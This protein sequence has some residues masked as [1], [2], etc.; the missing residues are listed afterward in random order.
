MKFIT[1]LHTIHHLRY[2]QIIWRMRCFFKKSPILNK[3]NELQRSTPLALGKKTVVPFISSPIIIEGNSFTFLNLS[4]Q[5]QSQLNWNFSSYGRLWT[6]NLNYFDFLLQPDMAEQKGLSL[7]KNYCENIDQIK[8]G[9]EPYPVSLR[10]INWIKFI[11]KFQVQDKQIDRYLWTQLNLLQRNL[12]YHLMGNHLLENAFALTIGSAYFIDTKL[13]KKAH[14]LLLNELEEQILEDGAH[15]ELSPMY[16]QIILGRL[17]DTINIGKASENINDI[18]PFLETKAGLMLGWL[19]TISFQNGDIPL[20]NDSAHNIA[21]T[22]KDLISYG[23]KLGIKP[24]SKELG[25]SGYRKITAPSQL[26]ECILDIGPIGPDYQ[27]GHAHADTFTFVL[28]YKGKPFILDTGT[29]T[30]ESG[31]RRSMERSTAAHNT[32]DVNGQDSSEVWASHRVGK[33]AR[34]NIMSETSNKIIASHNGFK[35]L[36]IIHQR[37]FEFQSKEL[38]ILDELL[39]KS[40]SLNENIAHLHFAPGFI[41]VIQQNAIKFNKGPTIKFEGAQ[42]ILHKEYLFAPEFNKTIPAQ[43]IEITF[44]KYLKTHIHFENS[45]SH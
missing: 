36:N 9:L 14:K 39:T 16:H 41:P 26:Y 31:K 11:L 42:K 23:N 33:R 4:H 5:F 3:K 40:D 44:S 29:S 10:C 13:Y 19:K 25:V 7:I 18:L 34:V 21:P 27:P 20:L 8:D 24:V 30:Y 22:T 38:F 35:S 17:L 37:S 6:Y 28:N 32:V 45:V 2:R 43:K 15:F 12:E 1:L